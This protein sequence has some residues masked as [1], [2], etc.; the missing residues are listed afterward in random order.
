MLVDT[1]TSVV[2]DNLLQPFGPGA[3]SGSMG[4]DGG[5]KGL[6][7]SEGFRFCRDR[8]LGKGCCQSGMGRFLFGCGLDAGKKARHGIGPGDG[9]RGFVFIPSRM[10]GPTNV[11]GIVSTSLTIP[12]FLS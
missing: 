2:V 4:L 1:S 9:G 8:G 12:N 7:A 5:I 3:Y 11:I 10:R 6:R